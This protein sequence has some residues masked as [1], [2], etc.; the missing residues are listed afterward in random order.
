[1]ATLINTECINC[2]ACE[3]ECPNTAI[4]QGGVPWLALDGSSHP[5]ISDELFYI[6]PEKC[7]ECVGF[8][9]QEACAKVCPVDACVPDPDRP[10]T[11][12]ALMVRAREIHPDKV[13]PDDSPSRFRTGAAAGDRKSTRLN[14]SHPRLSRMPSSA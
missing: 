10:E 8:F 14:S 12:A 3:P 2:A 5:A 1:M 9:D 13:I 6:V 7:T 11:E 4:Y